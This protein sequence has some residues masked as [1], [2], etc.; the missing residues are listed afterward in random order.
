MWNIN[1]LFYWYK[2]KI[3]NK[4]IKDQSEINC[5]VISEEKNKTF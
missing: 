5:S 2:N 3:L 4:C 1:F